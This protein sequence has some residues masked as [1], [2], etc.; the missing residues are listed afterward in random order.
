MNDLGGLLQALTE[1]RARTVSGAFESLLNRE[2]NISREIRGIASTSQNHL[3]E[4]LA[5]ERQRDPTFPRIL[6]IA[7]TDFLGGSFARHTKNWPLDDIDVYLPLD[8]H[9]LIYQQGGFRLPYTVLSDNVMWDNPLLDGRWMDGAYISSSK[10]INEFALVLRRHYPR[11]TEVRPNGAAVSIRMTHGATKSGDGLGYDV[12]PCFSLKPDHPNELAF[13][14]IPDGHNGWIRTNPRLDT[15][16]T[17]KLQAN[18]SKTFRKTVKLIKYWNTNI[19]NGGLGSYYIELA[20]TRAFLRENCYR[21]I[22]SVSSGV[23]LGFSAIQQALGN[24]NQE[25]W[26]PFAPPVESGYLNEVQRFQVSYATF[27]SEEAR[28]HED[29]GRESDALQSWQQVFGSRFAS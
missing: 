21:S 19:L 5:T 25:S 29:A 3:R 4:F 11:E 15:S 13:Y 2:I 27:L 23:A 12:V 14:L 26:I 9:A 28:R 22:T 1:V 18:N 7:D 20:I 24:G 16:L 8:G 17:E 10:L 6:S